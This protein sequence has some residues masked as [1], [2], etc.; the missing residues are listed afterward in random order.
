MKPRKGSLDDPPEDP[1]API[2][3]GSY[4]WKE[5]LD[6]TVP[7]AGLVESRRVGLVS[8]DRPRASERSTTLASKGRYRVDQW[9][10]LRAV[11]DIRARERAR[12]RDAVGVGNNMVLATA[13]A[14]IRR[15]WAGFFA[16]PTARTLELS[17]AATDR[18]IASL[19]RSFASSSSWILSQTPAS[20]HSCSRRQQVTPEPH[21]ISLGR[22]SQ[23]IPVRR[24][25]RMPVRTLRR[26]TG[27]R[28]GWCLLRGFTGISGSISSH[29]SSSRIGFAIAVPPCTV[30]TRTS[31][32][33]P[34]QGRHI[35]RPIISF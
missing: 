18:S 22:Y 26:S 8:N 1:E 24:T 3:V 25:K 14:P 28:P 34:F 19:A 33:G 17:T 27:F 29:S 5:W 35:R 6:A 13:F 31:M 21:P 23:G 4:P 7:E 20:C 16:P 11:M 10:E 2:V 9:Q 32:S 30:T 15:V 12:E